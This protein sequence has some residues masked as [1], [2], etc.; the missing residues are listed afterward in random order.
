[1]RCA[2]SPLTVSTAPG[3][4]CCPA[5]P[6]SPPVRYPLL[7]HPRQAAG[8]GADAMAGKAYPAACHGFAGERLLALRPPLGSEPLY[9]PLRLVRTDL[10]VSGRQITTLPAGEPGV[11]HPGEVSAESFVADTSAIE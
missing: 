10:D 5:T 2:R 9:D 7:R 1:M 3:R 8:I 4:S 11:V 6:K